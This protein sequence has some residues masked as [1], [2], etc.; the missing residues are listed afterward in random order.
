M[1]AIIADRE[2]FAWFIGDSATSTHDPTMNAPSLESASCLS[3]LKNRKCKCGYENAQER[4]EC[5]QNLGTAIWSYA[6]LHAIIRF[7]IFYFCTYFLNICFTFPLC[8]VNMSTTPKQNRTS[9]QKDGFGNSF[10]GF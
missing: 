7:F 6:R 8:H 3:R 10:V 2:S 5:S 1:L 9:T 4:H